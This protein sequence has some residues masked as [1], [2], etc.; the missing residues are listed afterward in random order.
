MLILQNVNELLDLKEP[1]PYI[2]LYQPTHRLHPDNQQDPIL[3]RNLIK[4]AEESLRDQH[5][6]EAINVL[7]RPFHDLADDV[8]FWS[9][10]AD[11]LAVFGAKDFFRLMQIQRPTAQLVS[12][13]D[14]F[15]VKPLLRVLQSADRFQVLSISR[16]AVRL[17]EGNR[18]GLDE[19]A[20][21]ANVP[22]TASAVIGE[23]LPEPQGRIRSTGTTPG[24]A[25]TGAAGSGGIRY[26][27][28]TKNEVIDQ[29]TERFFREV[30][31]AVTTHYSKPSGMPLIL[32]ALPEHHALFRS[33][34]HNARLLDEGIDVN[35]DALSTDELRSH[36]WKVMAPIYIRRLA[37]MI[38]QFNAARDT[39]QASADL[40]DVAVCAV[41][42]RVRVLLLEADRQIPGRIDPNTGAV[43]F[44]EHEVGQSDDMLDDLGERV[45]RAG[46]EV[47]MVPTE[48]MP[49]K[50]G[51]A[52][53]YRY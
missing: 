16:Q 15:H 24:T 51:L 26:T 18:D 9:H 35:P 42:G 53:I 52:A 23:E 37:G 8:E 20:L 40:S 6:K 31:R 5:S 45:L 36:A 44:G 14:S 33:V 19:I 32:A 12:V 21:D 17:F 27:H 11:G 22:A 28:G 39:Q 25:P 47:I 29:Q 49:S 46:G 38:D 30:D 7:L 2:S 50:T 3:F 34:S 4:K 41:A 1:G 43:H 13:S 10:T 48:R